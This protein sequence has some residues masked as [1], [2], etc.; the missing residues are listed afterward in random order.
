MCN[1]CRSLCFQV[2][3]R[4][5]FFF[6]RPASCRFPNTVI[7]RYTLAKKKSSKHF[8]VFV[9][10]KKFSCIPTSIL[11]FIYLFIYLFV[12]YRT[13]RLFRTFTMSIRILRFLSLQLV[14]LARVLIWHINH[15]TIVSIIRVSRGRP[16]KVHSTV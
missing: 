5:L 7:T 8:V 4:S 6:I 11:V 16:Y 13:V 14:N 15:S 1:K 3:A 10:S 2:Y 12:S 9:Y